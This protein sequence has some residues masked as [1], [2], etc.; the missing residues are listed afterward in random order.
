ML[1]ATGP[2][3]HPA[4]MPTE[5]TDTTKTASWWSPAQASTPTSPQIPM[6][7]WISRSNSKPTTPKL[8]SLRSRW[9]L[10]HYSTTKMRESS[11]HPISQFRLRNT[12]TRQL[13]KTRICVRC[14]RSIASADRRCNNNSSLGSSQTEG[15]THQ[16]S[17]STGAV[18]W[19]HHYRRG[20]RYRRTRQ[21]RWRIW[22][23]VGTLHWYRKRRNQKLMAQRVE[24]IMRVSVRK[25]R[26]KSVTSSSLRRQTQSKEQLGSS[27]IDTSLE[28]RLLASSQP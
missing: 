11:L 16:E 27:L 23:L 24:S 14:H 21:R 3:P 19:T 2:N 15:W 9:N 17:T 8:Q 25:I 6:K 1:E 28:N 4:G 10:K 22:G 12:S 7:W 26:M 13:S 5:Q 18:R 20:W